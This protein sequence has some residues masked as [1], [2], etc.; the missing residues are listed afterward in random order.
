[1]ERTGLPTPGKVSPLYGA[2]LK[3]F[4]MVRQAINTLEASKRQAAK[5][6]KLESPMSLETANAVVQAAKADTAFWK[7]FAP[8]N[9]AL[10]AMYRVTIDDS[11][12]AGL[13]TPEQ[14]DGLKHVAGYDP[15]L[16]IQYADAPSTFAMSNGRVMSVTSSGFKPLEAGSKKA[17][18]ADPEFLLEN[19]IARNQGRIFRNEAMKRLYTIAQESSDPSILRV[20]NQGEQAGIEASA[21]GANIFDLGGNQLAMA[22]MFDGRPKYM[23]GD[24]RAFEHMVQFD[25]VIQSEFANVLG[26]VTGGKILRPMTTGMNPL[27]ALGNIPR[28]FFY[29]WLNTNTWSNS[30]V[31][32]WMPLYGPMLEVVDYASLI[33]D[34]WGHHIKPSAIEKEFVRAGGAFGVGESPVTF[35]RETLEQMTTLPE[36]RA[37][38]GFLSWVGERSEK[39][40]RLAVYKRTLKNMEGDIRSGA[41][42]RDEAVKVAAL[43]AR[44]ML[45]FDES[46]SWV[47]AV[48]TGI[49]YLNAAVQGTR[50]T[51]KGVGKQIRENPA[52]YAAK[53]TMLT[54]LGASLYFANKMNHKKGYNEVDEHEKLNNFIF[55]TGSESKDKD[56]ATRYGFMRIPKDQSQRA[57]LAAV[58]AILEMGMEGKM[59][60]E[61]AMRVMR[62]IQEMVP[63]ADLDVSP[64]LL[65]ALAGA[66]AKWDFWQNKSLWAGA[67]VK[68]ED[69]ITAYTSPLSRELGKAIGGFHDM[70]SPVGVDYI[71]KTV[72]GSGLIPSVVNAGLGGMLTT[73]PPE[74]QETVRQSVGEYA[75][76]SALG[77]FYRETRPASNDELFRAMDYLERGYNSA[78]RGIQAAITKNDDT[79]AL[80]IRAKW[81]AD[82]AKHMI[83]IVL[84]AQE[85]NIPVDLSWAKRYTFQPEDIVRILEQANTKSTAI[86]RRFGQRGELTRQTDIGETL[87]AFNL[88][89][90]RALQELQAGG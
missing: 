47:R 22:A 41:I 75:K 50:G 85:R 38:G 53:L 32:A 62:G 14:A 48:N 34:V 29:S 37:L 36:L 24:K 63:F 42:T 19:A 52:A 90:N 71:Y 45:P 20:A 5:G 61:A 89:P 39:W 3:K 2:G 15:R 64:P 49:P 43:Q 8:R 70:F 78:R 46:G 35:G 18:I 27:F 9:D 73:V 17:L 16:F 68:A 57:Y 69:E 12:N 30:S 88:T 82:A 40:G 87:R 25:P 66:G 1:M 13:I 10:D 51:L 83:P 80:R 33:P 21:K 86:G 4:A 60:S 23:I 26:W 55:M 6:I 28:D 76:R 84:Q 7:D 31:N 59:P 65:K 11:L 79:L 56:G 44:D 54:S 67:R 77:K 74:G 58:E 81:D 72:A